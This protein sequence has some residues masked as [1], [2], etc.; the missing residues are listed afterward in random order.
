MDEAV[1][2]CLI[3]LLVL[4][5]IA[6]TVTVAANLLPIAVALAG[7]WALSQ[8][9]WAFFTCLSA[10]PPSEPRGRD[11]SFEQYFLG[12]AWRDMAAIIKQSFTRNVEVA[13]QIMSRGSQLLQGSYALLLFPFAFGFWLTGAALVG[14]TIVFYALLCPVHLVV[15]TGG[16]LLTLLLTGVLRAIEAARMARNR[17]FIQCAQC[18]DTVDHPI[19]VCP[20]CGCHHERLLPGRFG[21]LRRRCHCGCTLPTLFVLGRN[22]RVPG[23][24]PKCM[25]QITESAGVVQNLPL[26]LFA[27]RSAGKSCY[28][29]ALACT[30]DDEARRGDALVVPEGDGTRGWYDEVLKSFRSGT[31]RAPTDVGLLDA[32][33]LRIGEDNGTRLVYLFD[34]AGETFR[35]LDQ[36]RMDPAYGVLRGAFLLVDPFCLRSLRGM[37]SATRDGNIANVRAS[38]D[39]LDDPEVVLGSMVQT[40]EQKMRIRPGGMI[41]VDLAVVVT[42]IDALRVPPVSN[43]D[44]DYSAV[45]ERWLRQR[46]AT[47]FT[48]IARDRF[49][50]VRYFGVSALG[51]SVDGSRR[52]F[53]PLG[54][55][56]PFVWLLECSG[57]TLA[58]ARASRRSATTARM[59]GRL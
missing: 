3:L 12:Q 54:V 59:E 32:V 28:A 48:K 24:C 56:G 20:G 1:G 37:A 18:H 45:I 27:G 26:A 58:R 52:P 14:F 8:Y 23:Y 36:M 9:L 25:G 31:E 43:G 55:L 15:V 50:A 5:A 2:G 33:I 38:T 53:Q 13:G 22:E 19:Y 17:A 4:V 35:T 11:N 47:Q 30:L 49:R 29:A 42:K 7:L 51:R 44:A 41:P 10:G 6:I 40:L 57:A 39:L 21:V 34:A 16:A 46:G